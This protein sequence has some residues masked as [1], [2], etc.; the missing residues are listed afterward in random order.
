MKMLSLEKNNMQ[1]EQNSR[2]QEPNQ[3]V[4]FKSHEYLHAIGKLNDMGE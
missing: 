1:L 3:A 2:A 4:A